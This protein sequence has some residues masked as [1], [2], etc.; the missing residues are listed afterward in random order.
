M[1]DSFN[2]RCMEAKRR[3]IN[4]YRLHTYNSNSNEFKEQKGIYAS[5]FPVIIKGDG[6]VWDKAALY[7]NFLLKER[8]STQLLKNVGNDLL[9]FLKFMEANSI[10]MLHVPIEKELRVTYRYRQDLLNRENLSL[11]TASQRISRII[12]FYE[13]CFN[14]NLF[15]K[16]ELGKRLPKILR[17]KLFVKNKS[18]RWH[19]DSRGF[20]IQVEYEST[21]L[22][23]RGI[24]SAVQSTDAI[25][26]GRQLHPLTKE[27]QKI[28]EGYL[29]KYASRLFHLVCC[30]AI[31]T[32]ARVQA[33]CT[34]RVDDIKKMKESRT[35]K[36]YY[37]GLKIGR[38]TT[39]D[40][41]QDKTYTIFFPVWLVED[42]A[43]VNSE[44]W[45]ERAQKSY[46]KNNNNYIFLS[47]FGNSLY[48][49]K[50]E[51]KDSEERKYPVNTL[52]NETMRSGESLR[53]SL[54][55]LWKKM[56]AN[57]E[58]IHKFSLHDLRA[59]F[60]LNLLSILQSTNLLNLNEII[61]EIKERMGHFSRETTENYINYHAR[62]RAYAR[63][64]EQ[65]MESIYRYDNK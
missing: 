23:I 21:D 56:E 32:G 3:I 40:N 43:Y 22:S 62:N 45:K 64:S 34:L 10:D 2:E 5:A 55:D 25:Q 47:K 61:E 42:H 6:T 58:P 29:A 48:T 53:K 8:K 4:Q 9:D 13:Y 39:I 18:K 11:T 26:D 28:F 65:Y 36:G 14:N 57:N 15:T 16:E 44:E 41:K 20:S 60:G 33:I 54:N 12:A 19:K 31:N 7:L 1:K 24:K 27:E 35:V 52:D 46:Y 38:T 17:E 37:K 30:I 63:I 50:I 59:T 51:N 49:S